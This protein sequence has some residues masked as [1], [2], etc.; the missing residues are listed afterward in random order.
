MQYGMQAVSYMLYTCC[1]AQMAVVYNHHVKA[2]GQ[3]PICFDTVVASAV[4]INSAIVDGRLTD[5]RKRDDHVG[6]PILTVYCFR[7]ATRCYQH[8]PIGKVSIYRLLFVCLFVCVCVCVFV[9]LRISP[10]WTK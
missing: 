1:M 9:R 5:T 6:Y 10:A 7:I 4:T 3:A 2:V 8:V